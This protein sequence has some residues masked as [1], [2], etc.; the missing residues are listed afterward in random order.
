ML[1]GDYRKLK[2]SILTTFFYG[3][4]MDT[5]YKKK[6]I[7]NN[8]YK[9]HE[10]FII[11]RHARIDILKRILKIFHKYLV[12][13]NKI[14]YACYNILEWVYRANIFQDII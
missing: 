14:T 13:K 9:T 8:K 12:L 3:V 2:L 4:K 5:N 11:V 10:D 6:N 1:V 7:I